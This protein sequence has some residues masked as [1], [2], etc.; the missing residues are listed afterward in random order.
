MSVYLLILTVTIFLVFIVRVNIDESMEKSSISIST[1]VLPLN[2]YLS[3]RFTKKPWGF[4]TTLAQH[5]AQGTAPHH[6]PPCLWANK[7]TNT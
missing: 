6:F 2:I 7:C 1:D 4:R 5:S 3:T